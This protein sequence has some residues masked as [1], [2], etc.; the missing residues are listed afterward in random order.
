MLS[1]QSYVGLGRVPVGIGAVLKGWN[2]T[3]EQFRSSD[4]LPVLDFRAMTEACPHDCFHCFTDKRK[5]T[6]TLAEIKRVIDEAADMG[7]SAIDYL[8][9]G[10]PTIDPWFF[11]IIEHT[12]ARGIVPI[13]FTDAATK[14]RNSDFVKRVFDTGACVCPKCDSLFNP[15][16]QNWV[17]GDAEGYYFRERN[18][19]IELLIEM[20]F[21]ADSDDGTTRLGFIMVVSS[22]NITE[23]PETLRLCRERNLW[24]VFTQFLPSGRSAMPEF[25]RG[26]LVDAA[27]LTEMRTQIAEIDREFGFDHQI[28]KN[29]ATHPCIERLEVWGNGDVSPCSGNEHFIGNVKS[30]SLRE[31]NDLVL[32]QFPVHNPKGFDG[33]CPYRPL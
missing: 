4:R 18:E 22:K 27:Q 26:L 9:E 8:G 14:M 2:M 20:G 33:H 29:F 12:T 3:E 5:R 17:V 23:V 28:W 6:L 30:Q 13:V 25:D 16:Y 15:N 32:A 19:A 11:E 31:L 1:E 7:A 21:S 10:E 24:I